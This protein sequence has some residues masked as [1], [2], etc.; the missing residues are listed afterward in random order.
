MYIYILNTQFISGLNYCLQYKNE[1]IKEKF[2]KN[3]SSLNKSPWESLSI[4]VDIKK[5]QV[6]YICLKN[7]YTI[8]EK[9]QWQYESKQKYYK[10][11]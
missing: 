4:F 7:K 1:N 5:F 8:I 9:T 2:F 3:S 10:Q 6:F 11:R